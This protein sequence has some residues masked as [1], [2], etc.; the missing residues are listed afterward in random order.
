MN[1]AYLL[2]G[3]NMGNRVS[4][5][6]KAVAHIRA[7]CGKIVKISSLFESDPWGFDDKNRFINQVIKIETA[8]SAKD[9]L[10]ELLNIE[11]QLGRVRDNTVNYSSRNIDIDIL[12]FNDEIINEQELKI[13]HPLLQERK[14]TLLPLNEIAPDLYHPILNKTVKELLKECKDQLDVSRYMP[15]K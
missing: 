9:L 13:P 6:T 14:F 4:T 12:F 1:T 11:L 8:M 5:I 2:L 3:G 15:I 7:L 10:Q